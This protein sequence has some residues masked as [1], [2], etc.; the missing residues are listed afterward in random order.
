MVARIEASGNGHGH[1]RRLADWIIAGP[2]V[3][4]LRIRPLVLARRWDAP[5]RHLVELCLQAVREGLLT[6]RWDLLCQRCRGAKIGTGE[7]DRLPSGAHCDTCNIGYD[8][9]VSRNVELTFQPA[10]AIRVVPAGEFR[11]EESRVG[12]EGGRTCRFRRSRMP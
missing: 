8:R 2:E 10:A 1:A 9:D 11:S 7:L 5:P 6:L 4:L 3:D 12:N